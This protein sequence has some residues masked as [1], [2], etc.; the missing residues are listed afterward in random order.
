M[1][2]L[3]RT[4]SVARYA[5]ILGAILGLGTAIVSPSYGQFGTKPTTESGADVREET[6]Y[7]RVGVRITAVGGNCHS[8]FGTIP[9]PAEWP[10]QQVRIVEEDISNSV[11]KVDYRMIDEGA[12]QMLVSVPNLRAGETAQ[13]LVT[14]EVRRT[15]G[16]APTNTDQFIL[17]KQLPRSARM[18]LGPSPYIET[19]HPKIKALAAELKL[20][21]E[22]A[23]VWKQIEVNYDQVRERVKYR[24]GELKGA[25]AALEDGHGDCEE[26]TSLFIAVCRVQGIPA[27]TVW[28]P[29]HCYPE[30][31]VEDADGKGYW[32]PCQAAGDRA[33]GY[34]PDLRPILQKGD[35]FKVP[36]KKERQRYVAEF[37]TGK[38]G[39]PDVR[40]VREVVTAPTGK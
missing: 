34:M 13:A 24:N 38:K 7:W 23:T 31:Y 1:A 14:F 6:K 5:I 2:Q 36:E 33:F 25:V 17:P 20:K 4:H 26:L 11:T 12:R 15:S 19:R 10:D 27:R 28:V 32:F 39:K 21:E 37:L 3:L 18:H 8:L 22:E 9:V 30:F 40:F 29:D 16:E 35:N